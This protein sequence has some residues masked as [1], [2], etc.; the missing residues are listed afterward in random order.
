MIC[1]G[2]Y[3][4]ILKNDGSVWACGYNSSGQLGLGDATNKSKFTQVTTNISDVKQIAC[5]YARTSILKNDG[6]VWSCG[7]NNSG[8]LG[9]GDT[10]NRN[11]F[12]E[13]YKTIT[14]TFE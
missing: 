12:T 5:G 8:Q 4:F 13:T 3:T 14:L 2:D 7:S 1:G 6:S 11:T 10:T 9:L